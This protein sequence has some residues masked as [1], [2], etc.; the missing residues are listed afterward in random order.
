MPLRNWLGLLI[1][2]AVIFLPIF[3]HLEADFPMMIYDEGR[4]ANHALEM[5]ENG[6]L[7][8]IHYDYQP[9]MWSTK[10][11]LLIWLQA[12]SF[13]L[14]GIRDLSF[15]LPISIAAVLTCI[16]IYYFIRRKFKAPWLGIIAVIILISTPGYVRIH[17]IRTGDYD[18]LLVL[19]TTVLLFSF[20]TF[21]QT[22]VKKHFWISIA[23]LI[24]ACLTKGVAGLLFVPAM[25]LYSIQQRKLGSMLRSKELYLGILAFI[26]FVPGYYLLREVYNPGYIS[27][28]LENEVGG[29]YQEVKDNNTGPFSFYFTSF[30]NYSFKPFMTFLGLGVLALFLPKGRPFRGF[31][32]YLLFCSLIHVLIISGSATKHSW[33]AMPTLPLLAIVSAIP[34]YLIFEHFYEQGLPKRYL[35]Y[36]I[37]PFAF[38]VLVLGKPFVD[39]V[40]F[41]LE[42]KGDEGWMEGAQDMSRVFQ[43]MLKEGYVYDHRMKA[44]FAD[45]QSPVKWYMKA[46]RL[47]ELPLTQLK[48]TGELLKDDLLILYEDSVRNDIEQHFETHV[49]EQH[50]RATIYQI[51]GRK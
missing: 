50:G 12:L 28:V 17:G 26:V 10:P 32:L 3:A 11:P 18:G 16:Y 38:L 43:K 47:K 23:A 25:G 19:F 40:N 22:G 20:Y 48:D 44:I 6:N 49:V 35:R 8:V 4:L 41:A 24:L 1:V 36:N 39:S 45:T 27:A 9:E 29:R 21:I 31:A 15:R 42:T 33:Y 46:A 2:C 7:L 34:V 30:Y 51:H 14:F 13:K 37:L 5:Y